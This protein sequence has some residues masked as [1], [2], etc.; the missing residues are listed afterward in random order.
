ML[1]GFF[2]M[3]AYAASVGALQW[4]RAIEAGPTQ[5]VIVQANHIAE[6]I[7]AV[8][9]VGGRITHELEIINAVGAQ[10]TA[11]QRSVLIARRDVRSVYDDVA[12]QTAEKKPAAPPALPKQKPRKVQA[13]HGY[14]AG[15]EEVQD[16]GITGQGVTVA[17]LDS[18]IWPDTTLMKNR[19]NRDRIVAGYNAITNT[20]K[21]DKVKDQNGHGSHVSSIIANSALG[22]YFEYNG[23]APDASLVAVQ[24]FDENGTAT[25]ANVIRAINWVVANKDVYKIRVLNCSF[26]APARSHYWDDPI[27][28]AIMRAW[29][30]GIV[31]V[32]S[33]GNNGPEAMTIGVPGNVPYIITVGAMTD[34]FT[35]SNLTDDFLATF[36][37]AGPTA[38]GFIKP[39]VVAPGGHLTGMMEAKTTIPKQHKEYHDGDKYFQMSGTSQSTAVVSG[40]VALMLQADPLLTPDQVKYRLMSTARPALKA[41]R[42]LAYSLFQQG[43]GL[44]HAFDAIFRSGGGSANVGLDVKAD[45]AGTAHF[46]GRANQDENG[47]YYVMGIDGL[48][49]SSG[50]LWSNGL[51]WSD[52]LLW[53]NGLLWSDGFLWSDSYL[54]SDSL[55]FDKS[56]VKSNSAGTA[57]IN[58]W[59]E[60]Q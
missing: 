9:D 36:S 48:L 58:V 38:E 22:S 51:L 27:N 21:L 42:T 12:V 39:D 31:V 46:G 1:R 29:Q 3:L 33:A 25:Y 60:E 20:Q 24:A 6:A 47:N 37:S 40:V 59:V 19:Y 49:W 23:I 34:N 13:F 15:A 44:I 54:W 35:P 57:S 28:Q 52:G 5:S 11:S 10:V 45:L 17:V 43:A 14:A 53:S 56:G 18:G 26:S 41:N 16:M 30:A 55:G 2:A 4:T 8:N 50:L 32:A 7:A